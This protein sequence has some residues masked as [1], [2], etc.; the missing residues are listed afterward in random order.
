MEGLQAKLEQRGIGK[1]PVQASRQPDTTA[2]NVS[3]A[4]ITS[5]RL[6]AQHWL[7]AMAPSS[8]LLSRRQH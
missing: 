4:I 7:G 8:Q 1:A 2:G 6:A 3:T 5:A